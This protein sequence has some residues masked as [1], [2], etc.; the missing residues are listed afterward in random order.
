MIGANA[1]SSQIA[2]ELCSPYFFSTSW[3]N[4]QTPAAVGLY[5]N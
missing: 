5:N 3:Q 1:G 2:G 4:N